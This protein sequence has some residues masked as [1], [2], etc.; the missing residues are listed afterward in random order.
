MS[1][2]RPSDQRWTTRIKLGSSWTGTWYN[3]LDQSSTAWILNIRDLLIL[4]WFG[5][6]DTDSSA[7]NASLHLIQANHRQINGTGFSPSPVTP[8]RTGEGSTRRHHCRGSPPRAPLHPNST[9][10]VLQEECNPT[11]RVKGIVSRIAHSYA[12]TTA[13]G[14]STGMP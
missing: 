12:P 11:I 10:M 9:P 13:H 14:G 1:R 7:Q 5:S 6:D 8:A 3:T 4:V 2:S